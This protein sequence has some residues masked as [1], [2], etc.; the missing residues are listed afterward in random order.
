LKLKPKKYTASPLKRVYIPK[1]GKSEKRPLG[2]PTMF[3]RA[4][5]ALVKLSVDPIAE[6]KADPHSYGFRTGKSPHD[7]MAY[8]K[9]L[10]SNPRGAE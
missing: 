5:Q 6:C 7:A 2:I 1:P 9:I 4:Y 3:D 8:L 10:L